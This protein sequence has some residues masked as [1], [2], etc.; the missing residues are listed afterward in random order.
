MRPKLSQ[1]ILL[2]DFL[3]QAFRGCWPITN[4]EQRQE[5]RK[6]TMYSYAAVYDALPTTL[7]VVSAWFADLAASGVLPRS[8]AHACTSLLQLAS[9]PRVIEVLNTLAAAVLDKRHRALQPHATAVTSKDTNPE[10][11]MQLLHTHAAA[12]AR[13]A[14]AMQQQQVMRYLYDTHKPRHTLSSRPLLGMP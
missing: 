11:L 3:L 13:T 7:Q 12:F 4:R 9:G 14:D 5:F 10:Q 2:Y 6:V 1:D 8:A